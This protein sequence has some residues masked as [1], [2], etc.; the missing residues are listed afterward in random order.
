M[1]FTLQAGKGICIRLSFNA[2]AENQDPGDQVWTEIHQIEKY[3]AHTLYFFRGFKR[4]SLNK[5]CEIE[6]N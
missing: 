5:L 3:Q 2:Q 6:N 4:L 1:S